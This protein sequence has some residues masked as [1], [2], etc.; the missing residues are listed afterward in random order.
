[1]TANGLFQIG[2]YLAVLLT[3]TKP[4]GTFMT[5]VYEGQPVGISPTDEPSG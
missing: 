3:L 1:M 2:L 5:R 4:L